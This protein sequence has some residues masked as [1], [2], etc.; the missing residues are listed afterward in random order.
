MSNHDLGSVVLAL[1]LL[2][3]SANLLGHLFS[4]F[5]QPKVVGEIVAGILLGPTLLGQLAPDTAVLLFGTGDG[6]AS[7]IV[8]SFMY[9]LG[10]LLLMFV[11][12]FSVRHVLGKE[13]RAPTAWILGVGTPLPF[14]IALGLSPWLPIDAF[15][16]EVG[17][18]SAV[19]LVF[20]VAA[21]VTSI[22]V[23][24]KIFH[25]LGILHTRFA[26]L[27]LGAAVFED[28]ML[29]G[30][31][32]IATAIASA[33]LAAAQGALAETITSHV[34]VNIAYTISGLFVVPPLLRRLGNARW[35]VLAH[36][37]PA[38]W[39]MTVF[40]SYVAA[41]A[42]LNVTLVFGAFLAGIGVVGGMKGTDRQRYRQALDSVEHLAAAVFVPIYFALVGFRLDLRTSLD[43]VM[44][45]GFLVGTSLVVIVSI[46]LAGR[47]AGFRGLDL[48][49]LAL[50]CN[51]R[52]GPGIV[53]A[54]VAFDAGIINAPF[55]TTL[56]LTAVLS[57]Q[58]CGFWLDHVLRKGWPLLSGTDLRRRGLES[59][60]DELDVGV[61]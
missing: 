56:V 16:G 34:A 28:I 42:V 20:A 22:P 23:I 37:S 43:A 53:L 1:L 5:R 59:Y 39:V 45:L 7:S 33:T 32:S 51:A 50:T 40:F 60:E 3:V 15:V 13:N 14:F 25:D 31:L 27:V 35:N 26:S 47:L 55:F 11:S 44:L 52:G 61:T 9:H 46:G 48:V 30:V 12:G 58:A 57:S 19:V 54:S 10:L 24:T 4:R 18:R 49:N 6:D 36:H 41:A 17:S 38:T 2:L 21:A 8:L 29:W